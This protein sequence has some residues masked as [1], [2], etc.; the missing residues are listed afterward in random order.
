MG[1][2]STTPSFELGL[3]DDREIQIVKA[4]TRRAMR[5]AP[6]AMWGLLVITD[7]PHLIRQKQ[8]ERSQ[9]LAGSA[10]PT[11]FEAGAQ[12]ARPLLVFDI[13]KLRV[14]PTF[15]RGFP[16]WVK[17]ADDVL[18]YVIRHELGHLI[19]GVKV[20]AAERLKEFRRELKPALREAAEKP[21]V[22]QTALAPGNALN[23]MQ[24][25]A[26]VAARYGSQ[27]GQ[28]YGD[29]AYSVSP[30]AAMYITGIQDGS[31]GKPI[32]EL[33]AE[34]FATA[35]GWGISH[36]VARFTRETL[37]DVSPQEKIGF[38]AH[39]RAVAVYGGEEEHA[40]YHFL[41]GGAFSP[42]LDADGLLNLT[43]AAHQA[44]TQEIAA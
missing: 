44:A 9:D 6:S 25:Q 30:H 39:L 24:A 20:F 5:L 36:P 7:S 19:A 34:V 1:R 4:E 12:S 16:A 42:N 33:T 35:L 13:A 23:V 14:H 8:A 3:L 38:A 32:R 18:R 11:H 21:G 27:L 41:L 43:Q 15:E 17:T 40:A 2:I 31:V 29:A 26:R 22:R 10:T 28:L 37:V